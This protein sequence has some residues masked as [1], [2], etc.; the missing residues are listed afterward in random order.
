MAESIGL[1]EM[2]LPDVEG[3]GHKVQIFLKRCLIPQ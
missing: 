2:A 1:P 3:S